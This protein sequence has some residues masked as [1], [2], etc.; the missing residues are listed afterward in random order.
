MCNVCAL[1]AE[2]VKARPVTAGVRVSKPGNNCL[3]SPR[4]AVIA[5]DLV[6]LLASPRAAS[7]TGTEYPIGCCASARPSRV[8]IRQ[9]RV[10]YAVPAGSGAKR[11]SGAH[12]DRERTWVCAQQIMV[13]TRSCTAPDLHLSVAAYTHRNAIG[14]IAL[15]EPS[16]GQHL[17][18]NFSL[19]RVSVVRTPWIPQAIYTRLVRR[20]GPSTAI[21]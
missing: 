2:P 19:D 9:R 21:R 14:A 15:R 13:G 7:I 18:A 16:A 1:D 5:P 12:A 6:A 4:T 11:R 20:T 3:R 8:A 17:V 10:P